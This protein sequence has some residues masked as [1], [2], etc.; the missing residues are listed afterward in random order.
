[1]CAYVRVWVRKPTCM[2]TKSNSRCFTFYIWNTAMLPSIIKRSSFCLL[3]L[4]SPWHHGIH[5]EQFGVAKSDH[6]W[7][8]Y[9]WSAVLDL[10]GK[11]VTTF[12]IVCAPFVCLLACLFVCLFVCLL[13]CLFVCSF[14]GSFLPNLSICLFVLSAAVACVCRKAWN[15]NILRKLILLWAGGQPTKWEYMRADTVFTN[16]LVAV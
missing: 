14:R 3:C 9:L 6:P 5:K 1:M 4:H 7:V 12:H 2:F 13:V 15:A 10:T 16:S 8:E 11:T